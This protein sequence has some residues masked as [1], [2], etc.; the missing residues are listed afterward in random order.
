MQKEEARFNAFGPR[1]K[2]LRVKGKSFAWLFFE[3][4]FAINK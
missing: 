1:P 2:K 4:R 3:S